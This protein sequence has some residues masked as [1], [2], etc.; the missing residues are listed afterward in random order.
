M[1]RASVL[2]LLA[3]IGGADQKVPDFVPTNQWQEI[4]E[5]Q[6][7]PPGLHVK[8]SMEVRG[9]PSPTFRPFSPIPTPLSS[10]SS[11]LP[12]LKPTHLF[13]FTYP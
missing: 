9:P 3:L 13:T 11:S 5:G 1:L 12:S 7:I 4:M 6:A 2:A 8:V 10:C